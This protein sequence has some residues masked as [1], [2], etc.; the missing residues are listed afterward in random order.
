MMAYNRLFS[1]RRGLASAY[2]STYSSD[3][4]EAYVF[5]GDQ[6]LGDQTKVDGDPYFNIDDYES[7]LGS[8]T[9]IYLVHN[10]PTGSVIDADEFCA[11][12]RYAKQLEINPNKEELTI[13]GISGTRCKDCFLYAGSELVVGMRCYKEDVDTF[14]DY[15]VSV[16]GG[17]EYNIDF[18]MTDPVFTVN[19]GSDTDDMWKGGRTV[20]GSVSL[21]SALLDLELGA[22]P[23][24]R[25]STTTVGNGFGT[26]FMTSS[27]GGRSD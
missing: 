26:T 8:Y 11:E 23:N 17:F 12:T 14:C 4:A 15:K 2:C 3:L 19:T 27:A 24:L 21:G 18:Q 25:S 20:L 5:V 6:A 16:T 22:T 10:K 9:E 13:A 7:V 1:D